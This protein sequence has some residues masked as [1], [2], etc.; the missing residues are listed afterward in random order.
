MTVSFHQMKGSAHKEMRV[1]LKEATRLGW[2]IVRWNK[3]CQLRHPDFPT[4]RPLTVPGSPKNPTTT[5]KQM[6]K[7]LHKYAYTSN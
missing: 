7:R 1:V 4:G 3:H 6:M 2:V 5:R